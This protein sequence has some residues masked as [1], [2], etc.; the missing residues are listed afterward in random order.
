MNPANK[1]PGR[2]VCATHGHCFDG[3]ASAAVLRRIVDAIMPGLDFEVLACGYGVK[4]DKPTPDRLCGQGNAIVDFRYEPL[5]ELTLYF[6][7]HRTAFAN[8]EARRHFE[9]RRRLEPARF[10]FDP[11]H[12]SCTKLIWD[13]GQREFRVDFSGLERLVEWADRI[14][15]ARFASAEEATD[16]QEPVLR[17]ATVIEQFGDSPFVQRAVDVLCQ[18]GLD[19]LVYRDFV[20]DAFKTIEPK[21]R[22]FTER[23]AR[24][25]KQVGRVAFADLTDQPVNSVVKF[26]QYR[27]WPN[28][29]YS[30]MVAR[31]ASGVRIS[32]GH[33]PWSGVPLDRDISEIC[34]RYGGGGHPM[35]GGIGLPRDAATRARVIAAEISAE[36][37]EKAMGG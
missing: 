31:M 7:H 23:V 36:L 14:D 13:I 3:L 24:V 16:R 8:D 17:L 34:A 28:A 35:V 6:D 10:V 27:L 37:Q 30:V 22:E 26:I 20:V 4:Q 12:S 21:Q 29:A 18:E 25:G 19:S 11:N 33:N 5:D 32:V 9:E 1:T 2:F 15:A